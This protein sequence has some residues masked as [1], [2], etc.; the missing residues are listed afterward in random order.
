MKL[1]A[2]ILLI[3][4]AAGAVVGV[5]MALVGTQGV[6]AGDPRREA[7]AQVQAGDANALPGGAGGEQQR[8]GGPGGFEHS[9]GHSPSL[10]GAGEM[11]K[12]LVI[13]ALIVA[14]IA[15]LA[16]L[17]GRLRSDSEKRANPEPPAIAP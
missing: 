7:P 8:G 14:I 4:A 6:S 5:T 9:G 1:I 12:D 17:L 3:L 11:L 15:P 2:R 10:F 16:R 13:I